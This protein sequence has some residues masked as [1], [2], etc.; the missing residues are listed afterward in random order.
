MTR[1]GKCEACRTIEDSKVLYMPNPPFTHADDLTVE[2]WN[3]LLADNPCEK[4]KEKGD[5]PEQ[6]GPA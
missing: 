4:W 3:T 1:C 2:A 5:G 6:A